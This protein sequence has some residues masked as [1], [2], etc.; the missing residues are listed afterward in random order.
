MLIVKLST[1]VSIEI[2]PVLDSVGVGV[3]YASLAIGE[4]RLVKN[5]TGAAM[6]SAASITHVAN[7]HYTLSMTTGNTDTLGTLTVSCHK[8]GYQMPRAQMMVVPVKVYDSIVAGSDN[9]EVDA[10]QLLGTAILTPAVAGT[11]DVNA[12]QF[13]GATVTAT[14]SVT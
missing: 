5:G 14:T 1:A 13:G 3:E 4:L 8:T 2:G 12:K 9:L 11:L 7:G 6:A 10:I